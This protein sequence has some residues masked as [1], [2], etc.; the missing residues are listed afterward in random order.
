[1]TIFDSNDKKL[2]F[3]RFAELLTSKHK[4][5]LVI[6]RKNESLYKRHKHEFKLVYVTDTFESFF[7]DVFVFSYAGSIATPWSD[8]YRTESIT[9][10]N[11]TDFEIIIKINEKI[12]EI[13]RENEKL[14]EAALNHLS[15]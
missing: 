8:L 14:F 9:I 7:F 10:R 13:E 4:F 12:N 1:M 6:R 3:Q 15:L 5:D 11:M 2:I